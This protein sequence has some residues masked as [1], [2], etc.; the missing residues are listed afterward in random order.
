MASSD[1]SWLSEYPDLLA[2][3]VCIISFV[4]IIVGAKISVH[5]NSTFTILNS[6]MLVFII[7]AGFAFAN[8]DYW[9]SD[10]FGYVGLSLVVFKYFS[11][12]VLP[13]GD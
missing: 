1:D 11:I 4:I 5:F 6:C 12:S 3:G 10:E 7:L 2:T 8:T 13:F 9:T